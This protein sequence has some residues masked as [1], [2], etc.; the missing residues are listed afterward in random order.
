M[1]VPKPKKKSHNSTLLKHNNKNKRNK[2]IEKIRKNHKTQLE[3]GEPKLAVPYGLTSS[4]EESDSKN[5][6][7]TY[8]LWVGSNV[9]ETFSLS[10]VSPKNTSFFKAMTQAADLDP[11]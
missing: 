3:N 4:A 1:N 7:Y 6:S 8:T 5:V 9:T 2:T 11:R 10:L